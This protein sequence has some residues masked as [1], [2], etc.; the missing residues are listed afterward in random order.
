MHYRYGL[1]DV[2]C[3]IINGIGWFN[4]QFITRL[5]DDLSDIEEYQM[6]ERLNEKY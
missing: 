5:F 4:H 1:N 6:M 3:N 2:D